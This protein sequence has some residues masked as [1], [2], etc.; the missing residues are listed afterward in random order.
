M[1]KLV[2]EKLKTL[3]QSSGLSIED[4]IQKLN[5]SRSTYERMEKGQTASWTCK[6]EA[7]CKLYQIELEVL[8][9]ITK[10]TKLSNNNL[11]EV[12]NNNYNRSLDKTI[13]LYERLLDEKNKIIA[14]LELRF[15]S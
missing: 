8:L 1:N 7:I 2:G 13:E 6:T 9:L 15:K 10:K 5:V 4:V 12:T 14:N 3:R 11:K